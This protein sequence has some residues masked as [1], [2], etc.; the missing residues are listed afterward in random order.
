[1][2]PHQ[3]LLTC[4]SL[5]LPFS[6][7]FSQDPV[8]TITYDPDPFSKSKNLFP[9]TQFTALSHYKNSVNGQKVGTS[10]SWYAHIDYKYAIG[11]KWAVGLTLDLDRSGQHSST[12]NY[13]NL[14]RDWSVG[15][16]VLRGWTLSKTHHLYAEADA[17]FGSST[18]IYKTPS[19]DTKDKD[20]L[21]GLSGGIGLLS[22]ID[23][24]GLVYHNLDLSYNYSRSKNDFSTYTYSGIML[25]TNLVSSLRCSEKTCNCNKQYDL[26]KNLYDKGRN[27]LYSS[28][29][30]VT[31]GTTNDEYI[32]GP[33]TTIQ[34]DNYFNTKLRVNYGHYFVDDAGAGLHFGFMRSMTKSRDSDIKYILTTF[35]VAPTIFVHIPT[36]NIWNNFFAEFDYKFGSQASKVEVNNN[37]TTDKVSISGWAGKI[38]YDMTFAPRTTLTMSVGFRDRNEKEKDI[39]NPDEF[40]EKGIFLGAGFKY[41]W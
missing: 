38:G 15:P 31:V 7:V 25:N 11:D 40:S 20:D 34:K 33:I 32:S 2:K 16:S 36:D 18:N 5:L 26:S 3:L 28:M 19:S 41:T 37:A 14:T 39:S 13:D 22:Q 9:H 6:L 35:Y 21:F 27:Y 10:D 30:N 29:A 12:S 24:K 4:L 17:T 8:K 1:M 23:E